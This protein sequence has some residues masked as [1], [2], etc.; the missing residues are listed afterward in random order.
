LPPLPTHWAPLAV[1]GDG[2]WRGGSTR[3]WQIGADHL[4]C[5]ARRHNAFLQTGACFC[6]IRGLRC[7]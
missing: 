3:V 4:A 7:R 5:G 1:T 2:G 6:A